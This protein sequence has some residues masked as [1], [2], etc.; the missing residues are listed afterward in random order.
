MHGSDVGVI[1]CAGAANRAVVATA[2]A[3]A[4]LVKWEN[5]CLDIDSD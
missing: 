3:G 1:L 2:G 4:H 5:V